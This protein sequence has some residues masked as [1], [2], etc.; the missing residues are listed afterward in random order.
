MPPMSQWPKKQVNTV[1]AFQA[2][3]IRL[4]LTPAHKIVELTFGVVRVVHLEIVDDLTAVEFLLALWRFI[5]RRGNPC[6]II[7]DK[8]AQ[9]KLSQSAIDDAWQKV[10]KDP[11]L[12]SYISN[13]GIKWSFII[14]LS[15]WMGGFY[16]RLVGSSNMALR[17]SIGKNYLTSLQLQTFLLETEAVLNS[18]PLVYIGDDLNDRIMITPSHFLS[19]NNYTIIGAPVIVDGGERDDPNLEPY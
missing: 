10:I 8:A 19:P 1:S 5:A 2:H 9:F 7:L 17:K 15:P 4:F 11:S 3:W 18:R 16:E 12:Q 14:E 6:E 13:Q